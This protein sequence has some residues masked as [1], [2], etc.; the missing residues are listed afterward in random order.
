MLAGHSRWV[1]SFSI[2]P[3][4]SVTTLNI[5]SA[6]ITACLYLFQ[7]LFCADLKKFQKLKEMPRLKQPQ[8][9]ENGDAAIRV[10]CK[11]TKIKTEESE[12]V[13]IMKCHKKAKMSV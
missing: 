10:A 12:P 6:I 8:K 4:I 11:K 13:K 3:C 2:C 5:L 1:L 7:V 9:E